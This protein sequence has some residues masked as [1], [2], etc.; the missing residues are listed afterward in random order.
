MSFPDVGEDTAL[1]LDEE[2]GHLRSPEF[3]VASHHRSSRSGSNLPKWQQRQPRRFTS[4]SILSSHRYVSPY[5]S[6]ETA[7]SWPETSDS[8]SVLYSTSADAVTLGLKKSMQRAR[9]SLVEPSSTRIRS[10]PSPRFSDPDIDNVVVTV[11]ELRNENEDLKLDLANARS[12]IENLRESLRREKEQ[13]A[14]KVD[15]AMRQL[16]KGYNDKL[17][18]SCSHYYR[19]VKK[20]FEEHISR[21]EAM[22]EQEREQKEELLEACDRFFDKQLAELSK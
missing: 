11:R 19:E 13:Q 3:G 18:E 2:V 8:T 10:I 20:G 17:R 15:L 7:S 14:N 9:A 21:L 5:Q 12:E 1:Y 16:R 6:P 22:L 4:Q